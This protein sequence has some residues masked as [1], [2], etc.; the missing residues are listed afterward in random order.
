MLI[1]IPF[2]TTVGFAVGRLIGVFYDMAVRITGDPN[3]VHFSFTK[4][5]GGQ[6]SPL[7]PTFRNVIE[8]NPISPTQAEITRLAAY[9]KER[10]ITTVFGVDVLVEAAFLP[11]LRRA[12]IRKVISYWGAPISSPN[13]GLW[14]AAKRLEVAFIR[15]SK[16]NHFI[17]E[18]EAMRSL[19]VHGRGISA[20]TTSIIRTGV[21]ADEFHPGAAERNTVYS[22]FEIPVDRRIIVYMGHLHERK[23]VHVLMQ[24]MNHIVSSM[25]RTDIQCLFLGDRPGEAEQFRDLA[26]RAGEWITF[27]GYQ[28]EIPE[29]LSGCYAGC[30]PSTG[31]DSFPMSSLEMQACGLPVIASDWQGV[32][33]T[34][35]NGKTGIA[36]PVDNALALAEAIVWLIDNPQKRDEMSQAARQWI[37]AEL[38][39]QHQIENLVQLLSAELRG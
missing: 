38:T 36:V 23:G 6:S 24:A 9:I 34:I 10:G 3:R 32:P 39:R 21:N 4:I 14:L 19:G 30:V 29:L 5:E 16:P 12:G 17:F 22:R 31:W 37:V 28:C 7:P 27:G 13:R 26:G 8:F 20:A 33:E 1:I 11:S 35:V 18:S 15:R 25:K 2:T